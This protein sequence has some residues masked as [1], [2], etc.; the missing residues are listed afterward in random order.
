M[1]A[2][3][4]NLTGVSATRNPSRQV[5]FAPAARIAAS[6]TSSR[7]LRLRPQVSAGT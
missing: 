7:P 2:M 6:T 5:R 1:L 4:L 3:P